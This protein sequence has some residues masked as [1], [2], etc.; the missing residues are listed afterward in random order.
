MSKEKDE[1]RSDSGTGALRGQH[2]P[3]WSREEAA[4]RKT[5]PPGPGCDPV[6]ALEGETASGRFTFQDLMDPAVPH[7]LLDGVVLQVAVAAVHLQGLV[8]DLRGGG[9]RW[10]SF[11]SGSRNQR[12]LS[13]P[14]PASC[15]ELT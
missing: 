8:A 4:G 14:Q 2:R 5:P 9:H 6:S 1:K 7:V 3:P 12:L 10:G 13:P 11:N 15:C